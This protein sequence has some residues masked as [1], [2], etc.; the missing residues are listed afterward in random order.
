MKRNVPLQRMVPLRRISA[1]RQEELRL[2]PARRARFLR[3][4]PYCQLWL[5]EHGVPEERAVRLAGVLRTGQKIPPVRVPRSAMVHHR[6]KRRHDRLLDEQFW[7]A[8]SWAGHREI[9]DHK[10]WARVRGYLLPF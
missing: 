9:E 1:R 6:N 5:A 8:V 10:E 4:H 7:M 3:D 2:Y